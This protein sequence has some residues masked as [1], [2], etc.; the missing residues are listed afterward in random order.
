MSV[1]CYITGARSRVMKITKGF[2]KKPALFFTVF[3]LILAALSQPAKAIET[4]RASGFILKSEETYS[5]HLS[6]PSSDV[7]DTCLPLLNVRHTSPVSA[8]DPTRRPAGHKAAAVGFVLGFRI[9]LG[10]TEVTGSNRV[11][12][13][14][15]IITQRNNGS[16]HALAVAD[17]RRCKNKQSLQRLQDDIRME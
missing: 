14:P 16:M 12:V 4:T 8:M 7:A 9:A 2:G 3:V 11:S 13:G 17:Y 6:N 10:P 15:E 1:Q 5:S